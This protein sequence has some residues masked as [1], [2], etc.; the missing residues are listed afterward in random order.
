MHQKRRN[1]L[2]LGNLKGS[3]H[4]H[5]DRDATAGRCA[6]AALTEG[7]GRECQERN[8]G[9]EVA[10]LV[11]R[12]LA[13]LT[14]WCALASGQDAS[15]VSPGLTH[16]NVV[17]VMTKWALDTHRHRHTHTDTPTPSRTGRGSL[18]YPWPNPLTFSRR[19][20]LMF[21]LIIVVVVIAVDIVLFA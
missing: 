16:V 19:L 5:F 10:R 6:A 14:V 9:G 21:A 20:L 15:K 13:S 18:I 8:E 1:L 12:G 17:E 11:R 3:A 4:T 7:K 2:G